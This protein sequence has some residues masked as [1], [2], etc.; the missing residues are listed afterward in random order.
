[1]YF[2]IDDILPIRDKQQ[3]V[4]VFSLPIRVAT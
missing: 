1:M 2:P 3:F 4:E